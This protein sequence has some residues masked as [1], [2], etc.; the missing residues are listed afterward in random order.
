MVGA[1]RPSSKSLA[2][3]MLRNIDIKSSKIIVEYGPGTGVFT[4]YIHKEMNPNSKLYVFELNEPFYKILKEEYKNEKNVR[5]IND[6]ALNI[7]S[8]LK[9]D[10][11]E[12]VDVIISSLPLMNFNQMLT[13]RILKTAEAVLKPKGMYIQYQYS[14]SAKKLLGKIFD[15]NSI[16]F[17]AINLPPA[18]IYTCQK[19]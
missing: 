18:F 7:R 13:M 5:I 9:E 17:T 12:F 1:V 8:Y 16:Q 15:L 6:S 11:E 19:K 3:K 14:L 4:R 10:N 2:K